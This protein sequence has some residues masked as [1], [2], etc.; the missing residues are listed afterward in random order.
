MQGHDFILFLQNKDRKFWQLDSTGKVVINANPYPLV[1]S[2]DGWQDTGIQNV[3]NKKHW[4]IDRTVTVPF[5]YVEDGAKILKHVFYKK[6]VEDPVYLVICE[7]RLDYDPLPD[8][9]LAVVSGGNPFTAGTNTGTITGTPGETVYIKLSFSGV[10]GS[11]SLFGNI[12]SEN[13]VDVSATGSTIYSCVVPPSGIVNYN[14]FFTNGSTTATA[15]IALCTSAGSTTGGY[16]FWYKQ[17]FRGE[18]D[19]TSFVHDGAYVTANNVEEGFAKHLKANENTVYELDLNDP[20]AIYVKGDGVNLVNKTT[21]LSVDSLQA[22]NGVNIYKSRWLP[23]TF[24]Q[25]EGTL[26]NGAVLD[27]DQLESSSDVSHNDT[28][29]PDNYFYTATGNVSIR[30]RFPVTAKLI[31]G[32]SSELYVKN[33]N[34]TRHQLLILNSDNPASS[35]PFIKTQ[36]FNVDVTV[37]VAAGEK[38]YLISELQDSLF[39]SGVAGGQFD[40]FNFTFEYTSRFAAT[41]IKALRGIDVFRMLLEKMTA[42]EFTA[43]DCPYL[44]VT[45]GYGDIVF[46]SGDAIRGFDDAVLKISFS[47]YMSFWNTFDEVG[48]KQTGN[49]IK[50]DRKAILI[51]T[52]ELIDLG[53]I[54]R[55]K[56][57]FN[58]EY[59]FNELSVGY[60]D[61]KSEEGMLNGRNEFNTTFN[62]SMGTSNN[63]RKY[64]KISK[65]KASCYDI[66]RTRID[67]NAKESTDNRND[68]DV[69]AIHIEDD[70]TAGSGD[71]P[72]HY[73]LDRELNDHLSGVENA[74]SVF[75]VIMSPKR[76]VNRSGDYLQSCEYLAT[77][78]KLVFG[79]ADRN[80]DME[81]INGPDIVIEKSDITIGDLDAKFFDPVT[82]AVE[83]MAPSDLLDEL[84][85]D[86]WKCFQFSFQGQTY[87]GIALKNSIN[88]SSNKSQTFELLSL[89]ENDLT[90]LIDYYG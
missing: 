13:L 72:D 46:T 2:P 43:D 52:A 66:E 12:G 69:Y 77:N 50:Q 47:Q 32:I 71:I 17:T 68:N 75:N 35:T 84:D 27:T 33:S 55:P 41:Y 18:V 5:K 88:P 74:D 42:G 85:T 15:G 6:G 53:E 4:S 57:S 87:K 11:D 86:E 39:I 10:T 9:I 65:I 40:E 16:A 19:L 45:T 80:K 79:T 62:W 37:P 49:K 36:T 51:N 21:F 81:Y 64:E 54:A 25:T 76:C 48:L 44:D 24:I 23:L 59:P 56:I 34:G 58:K 31:D 70:V 1:F 3:L 78:K 60:P 63:V 61:I 82:I 38:L 26:V 8:A 22:T 83:T 29:Y 73:Q 90:P 7:Q 89:A 20:A 30:F 14:I 28:D 67:T